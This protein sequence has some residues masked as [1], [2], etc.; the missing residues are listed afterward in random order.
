MPDE[1]KKESFDEKVDL[2]RENRTLKRQ[3]H[4]L[5]ALLNRNK[6]TLA[7]RDNINAM[8]AA[9][10]DKMNK[11]LNLLLENN[12]DIILLFDQE[13]RFTHC[14]RTFMAATGI[15]NS[16][17]IN[18]HLFTDIFK[19]FI[20]PSQLNIL[21]S[22]FSLAMQQ[23]KTVVM[24]DKLV[25]PNRPATHLYKIYII[26]MQGDGNSIEG[27]M[28]QCRDLTDAEEIIERSPAVALRV[29]GK[30]GQG[31]TAFITE[32][33]ATYGYSKK[34]FLSGEI[35]WADIVYPE[36]LDSLFTTQDGNK[37]DGIDE[38]SIIYRI[39]KS[40]GTPVWIHDNRNIVR[41]DNGEIVHSDCII[42]DYTETK[43]NL[44][45]IGDNLRQQA[46]LNDILQG[47][48]DSDLD[49][50]LQI[51]LDR[52]GTY[53][54]ISRVILF[55]KKPNHTQCKAIYEWCNEGISSILSKGDFSLD[56]QKDIL[57]TFVDLQ[58]K[59]RCTINYDD[60]TPSF[61]AEF[62]PK[63]V[64]ALAIFSVY[65][66]DEPFGFIC[67]DECIK[68]RQWNEDTIGFLQNIAKLVSTALIRRKNEQIIQNMALTDQLTKLKNR[69]SLEACLGKIISDARK[70]GQSGYVFFIDMDD[71]KIIND[72]YGHNYG[73]II[74]KEFATF[75][76]NDFGHIGDI[77]RFGGDEFVIILPPQ[78]AAS[79][80]H[81]INGLLSRAQSPWVVIDKSF[82]CTLSIGIASFPDGST[83]SG[84]IIK[85]ADIAM[86]QAKRVGK[87]RYVFYSDKLDNDSIT[88]AEIEK[89]MRESIDHQFRGFSVVYQPFSDINEKIIGAEALLRWTISSGEN[90]APIQFIP[91]AEYLGLIVPIG[92]F[93]L[94]QAAMLCKEINETLPSFRVSINFSIR[95]FLQNDF[96]ERVMFILNETG[97]DPSNLIFEIT[98]SMAIQD[99]QRVRNLS[100]E[101]RSYGIR[102]AMD[103]FGVGHSSL[104]NMRELPLDVV[105][106]DRTFIADVTKNDY[107]K[108]FIRLITDLVHSLGN[109][110]CIEGVETSKQL[111]YCKECNADYVQ[112]TFISPPISHD[113]L[114]KLADKVR[115]AQL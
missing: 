49:K 22:N 39:K 115:S 112:G 71:F 65:I 62:R 77:F 41:D 44:E 59:G 109:H 97:V 15:T 4:S 42:T 114:H 27:A 91:L 72:G 78:N 43:I 61:M 111:V 107:A 96:V 66:Q 54:G 45:K 3:L 63:D 17:I 68:E 86:Y 31:I 16:G 25:F 10:Q 51:I 13:G 32:N 7:A 19:D 104:G 87:N 56:Y 82:Y 23:R 106:I 110:V 2:L 73:D 74:L 8:L 80:D 88:R 90:V 105:K 48:H 67:F 36:D 76:E 84:D 55:E 29:T 26:P 94:R 47:L 93:V 6:S 35:T 53:L 18:G 113:E 21:Q 9:Q 24:E 81:I 58:T 85:K 99:I 38:Y 108:S 37:N 34:D 12:P 102:I 60:I 70:F 79:I 100:E 30:N 46:V 95:Q 101:F 83:S 103:D 50:S 40:D 98:E 89:E 52:T 5:E 11:N 28:I 57:D 1:I 33:I 75:L 64:I 92:E 14:T 20:S 69:H